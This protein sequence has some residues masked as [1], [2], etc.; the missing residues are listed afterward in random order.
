MGELD[1][2]NKGQLFY[3]EKTINEFPKQETTRF[4]D[5]L[6][7][8]KKAI[9]VALYE[10]RY[11]ADANMQPKWDRFTKTMDEDFKS[12]CHEKVCPYREHFLERA[13][14]EEPGRIPLKYFAE[15]YFKNFSK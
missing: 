12:P 15:K 8:K 2:L 9:R 13:E 4:N 3:L 6:K 11:C 5:E 10:C 1:G 7:S 14:N